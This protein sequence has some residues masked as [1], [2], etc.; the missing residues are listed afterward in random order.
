MRILLVEDDTA[1]RETLAIALTRVGYGVDAI[2]DGQLA[3]NALSD[4]R[5]DLVVLD[6]GLPHRDGFDILQR[7]RA[8]RDKTPVLILTAR[9][10]VNDR[11]KGLD[12]GADDY[13]TKPFAIIEFEARVRATLRRRPGSELILA[14]GNLS[15]NPAT[16]SVTLAGQALMLS[17][18]EISLL[19]VLLLNVG[20]VVKKKTLVQQLSHWDAEIG[21]NAIEVYIHRLRKRLA[22]NGI[23]IRTLFGLGYLLEEQLP[24]EEPSHEV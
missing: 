14:S 12:L 10:D 7:L 19:E 4:G 5:Y 16:R 15:L 22:P 11:V 8:R 23:I 24:T 6:I 13:M 1:L 20:Q 3:D 17:Q 21:A 9:D 18:R 2:A